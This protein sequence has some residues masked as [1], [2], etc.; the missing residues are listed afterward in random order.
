MFLSVLV[1]FHVI[2]LHINPSLFQSEKYIFILH[3]PIFDKAVSINVLFEK[4]LQIFHS[5]NLWTEAV[6]PEISM[7]GAGMLPQL[8]QLTSK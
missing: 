8:S 6:A 1:L 2:S 5:S 4:F 3:N 7:L